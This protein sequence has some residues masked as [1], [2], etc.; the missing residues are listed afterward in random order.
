MSLRFFHFDLIS[1]KPCLYYNSCRRFSNLCGLFGTL[2][3]FILIFSNA[4]ACFILWVKGYDISV[5]TTK[6]TNNFS[7]KMNLS[8]TI[9]F[10]KLMEANGSL[11]DPH[12]VTVVPTLWILD[13]AET[14]VEI[15]NQN[16]CEKNINYPENKYK[17]LLNFDLTNFQCL[18]R[19]NG[20]DIYL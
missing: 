6:E 7:S 4:M 2:L 9:F 1:E 5:I 15:L 17:D 16:S 13:D 19:T 18:S 11:V 20:K 10:Y 12:I 8:H 14:K 3:A